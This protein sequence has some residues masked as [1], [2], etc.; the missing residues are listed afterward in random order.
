LT[1]SYLSL[2]APR[3]SN[4][5]SRQPVALI[6]VISSSRGELLRGAAVTASGTKGE[7]V[8]TASDSVGRF[9]LVVD[10]DWQPVHVRVTSIGYAPADVENLRLSTG[11]QTYQLNVVLRPLVQSLAAVKTVAARPRP[12]RENARLYSTPGSSQASLDVASG[13]SGSLAGDAA[14]AL[15]MLPQVALVPSPTGGIPTVSAFGL[16]SD[17]NSQTLNG[18][19][20]DVVAPPRDGIQQTAILSSYDPKLGKFTGLQ[21]ASSLGSG[22]AQSARAIRLTLESPLFQS[23][24][25]ASAA[26]G[27]KFTNGI[28]SGTLSGPVLRGRIFYSVAYQGSERTNRLLTVETASPIALRALGLSADS[29]RRIQ[30]VLLPTAL[31]H[32]VSSPSGS[33]ET[34]AASILARID[35][36]SAGQQPFNTES[37]VVYV[38]VG[39]DHRTQAP[40]GGGANVFASALGSTRHRGASWIVAFAPYVASMLTE[41]KLAW[42]FGED[43]AGAGLAIPRGVV[44]VDSHFPDGGLGSSSVIFG[45]TG[46]SRAVTRKVAWQLSNEFSW[47]ST[48]SAHRFAVYSEARLQSSDVESQSTDLGVFQ[49]SSIADLAD[50]RPARYTRS[51]FAARSNS[52]RFHGVIG[53]S[54]QLFLSRSSRTPAARAGNGLTVQGGLRLD[55]DRLLADIGLDPRV[56]NLAGGYGVTRPGLL[57]LDPMLGFSWNDGTFRST[58]GSAMYEWTKRSLSG[59]I[60]AY[61]SVVP[62]SSYDAVLRSKRTDGATRLIDCTGLAVPIPD[63][64]NYLRAVESVPANCASGAP[65][66]QLGLSARSASFFAPGYMP[67]TSWRANLEW[68]WLASAQVQGNVGVTSSLNTRQPGIVDRNF[69]GTV[70]ARLEGE[71]NRPMFVEP[72]GIDAATG[73]VSMGGSRIDSEFS[74]ALELGSWRTSFQNQVTAGVT[75]LVGTSAFVS[76]SASNPPRFS[77]T[78]RAWYTYA[79]GHQQSSGFVGTTSGD[80]RIVERVPD[81]TPNHTFQLALNAQLDRWFSIT[82]TGRLASG[83]RYTPMIGSDANGDGLSNDRAFVF[84]PRGNGDSAVRAGIAQ[85]LLNAPTSATACL[86][87]QVGTIGRPLSCLGPWF[88]S[89]GT[90]TIAVDPFRMGFG[91]RGTITL[92]VDNL[93]SG[94]DQALNGRA[95]VRGWGTFGIPDQTLL[96]VRGWDP[97]ERKF[98]YSVNPFFG[99]T[100]PGRGSATNPF[101]I[102]FDVRLDVGV[103]R[104]TQALERLVDIAR[105]EGIAGD[106]KR[107]F[108]R[109]QRMAAFVRR[110]DLAR[111]ETLRDSLNLS[112]EQVAG[113]VVIRQDVAAIRDSTLRR[114]AQVIVDNNRTPSRGVVQQ[115]WHRSLAGL[116][117]LDYRSGDRARSLLTEHQFESWRQRY[118]ASTLSYS[119]DWLLRAMRGWI[120]QP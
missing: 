91:N 99:S 96:R 39:V 19:D 106:A 41:T 58:S 118:P 7:S 59:G 21:V 61:T 3:T 107:M 71:H 63:W 102:A 95:R 64:T 12:V 52:N 92:V 33:T 44:S 116:I 11:I 46:A 79:H 60:R 78:I 100:A 51:L 89:L 9:R 30:E 27:G 120:L 87:R 111:L 80:P 90:L 53:I 56:S 40:I 2:Y 10:S 113:I 38:L 13:Q 112:D 97:S 104:E 115:E 17:Q 4:A 88:A 8:T 54:D 50:A 32:L 76:P 16:G 84:D 14:L 26:Q 108:E 28:V 77:G 67:P 110:D 103:N 117:E 24:D 36:T 72:R 15:A 83:L 68:K 114:L 18:V 31:G 6:G 105:D 49:F 22:G 94:L 47:M 86:R 81:G 20:A 1:G 101:R 65:G 43:I 82:L 119:R 42:T 35:F 85:L 25:V 66:A 98:I 74:Q 23:A 48:S 70:R 109:L 62:Q 73:A 34:N 57:S 37:P 55:A 29:V 5:A 75:W 45:G 69:S 93:L